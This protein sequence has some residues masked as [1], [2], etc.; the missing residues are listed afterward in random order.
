MSRLAKF[1]SDRS[2]SVLVELAIA[3]PVMVGIVVGSVDTAR[4][5]LLHQRM[6]RAASITADLVSRPDTISTGQID[7]IFFAADDLLQPFTL[8][9]NGRV[10]VSSVSDPLSDSAQVDW[11]YAGGGSLSVTS[12]VGAP[13]DTP[14]LPGGIA[15]IDGE[16][17]IVAEVYYNFEPLF[18]DFL[19]EPRVLS[20]AAVRSP[21]RGALSTL[22]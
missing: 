18:I 8:A 4:Y 2:G 1:F 12:D 13:G 20:H 9:D 17:L 21:R 15:L 11:Q 16:N 7:A 22:N 3:V 6:D 5:I 14:T 19:L 10:I